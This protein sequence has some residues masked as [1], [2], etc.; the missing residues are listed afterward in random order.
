MNKESLGDVIERVNNERA[1]TREEKIELKNPA[2][3]SVLT[4][5]GVYH[6][7]EKHMPHEKEIWGVGSI[8]KYNGQRECSECENN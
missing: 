4:P 2:K 7:C 6:V 5:H 1:S 8:E 3:Y